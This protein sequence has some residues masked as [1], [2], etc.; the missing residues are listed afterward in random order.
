M[1]EVVLEAAPARLFDHPQL[2]CVHLCFLCCSGVS[3]LVAS[4]CNED[5][6][7]AILAILDLQSSI[8]D[9]FYGVFWG[10]LG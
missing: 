5:G 1:L 10:I 8:P 6:S 9:F 3:A 2:L 7:A 4:K